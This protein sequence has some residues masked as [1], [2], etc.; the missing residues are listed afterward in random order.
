MRNTYGGVLNVQESVEI[1]NSGLTPLYDPK[2]TMYIKGG[3]KKGELV[4]VTGAGKLFLCGFV[5]D[6]DSD[7]DTNITIVADGVT[8]KTKNSGEISSRDMLLQG[9]YSQIGLD[10]ISLFTRNDIFS[11]TGY[12]SYIR[13]LGEG[14]TNSH[15]YSVEP[16]TFKENL[17]ITVNRT[18][19]DTKWVY[20][21]YELAE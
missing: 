9:Y 19:G 5:G 13:T 2:T 1:V 11:T 3:T 4:N 20:I 16:M 18:S 17:K 12:G 15:L 6:D 7:S 10:T 14:I 8:F 21:L